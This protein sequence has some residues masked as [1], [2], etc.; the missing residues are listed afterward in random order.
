MISDLFSNYGLYIYI[1]LGIIVLILVIFV[2]FKI[3]TKKAPEER[4]SILDVDIDGVVDGSFE[5]GYEKEDTIVMKP[6]EKKK[7]ETKKKK[8]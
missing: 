1:G 7:K 2:I 6:V 8:K 3:V 5:Y 4:S